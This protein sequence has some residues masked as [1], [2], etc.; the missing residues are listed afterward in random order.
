MIF[1]AFTFDYC[2]VVPQSS[3]DFRFSDKLDPKIHQAAKKT[4]KKTTA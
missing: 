3:F 1:V 4:A 2:R